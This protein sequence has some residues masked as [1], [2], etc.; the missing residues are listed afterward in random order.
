MALPTIE[1][2]GALADDPTTRE[3]KTGHMVTARVRTT[4]NRKNE[5]GDW[6]RVETLHLDLTAFSSFNTDDARRLATAKKGDR[7][8]V[9]GTLRDNSWTK[10]DGTK[11]PGVRVVVETCTV[12]KPA[13]GQSQ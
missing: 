4:R 5:A 6:E 10:R 13:G 12:R 1:L 7:I 8:S 3:V 9:K 11:V 2:T